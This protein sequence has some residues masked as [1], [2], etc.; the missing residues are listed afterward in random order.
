MYKKVFTAFICKTG[1]SIVRSV[2]GYASCVWD[3]YLQKDIDRIEAIQRREQDLFVAIMGEKVAHMM[4]ELGWKSLKDMRLDQR[5]AIF[6]K[7]V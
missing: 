6:H 3:P 5:F 2:L 7:I 1:I 4:K